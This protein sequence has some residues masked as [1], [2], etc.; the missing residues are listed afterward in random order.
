M[1][2]VMQNLFEHRRSKKNGET[3][4]AAKICSNS[5]FNLNLNV[6][7]APASYF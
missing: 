1:K 4:K 2:V 6:R 3:T 7:D 5:Y